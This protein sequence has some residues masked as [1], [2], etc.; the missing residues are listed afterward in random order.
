[1]SILSSCTNSASSPWITLSW[2]QE[3][4]VVLNAWFF[5]FIRCILTTSWMVLQTGFFRVTNDTPFFKFFWGTAYSMQTLSRNYSAFASFFS[6]CDKWPNNQ[7]LI[8]PYTYGLKQPRKLETIGN[9]LL[10]TC[11]R[12]RA[13]GSPQKSDS[14]QIISSSRLKNTF[15]QSLICF[16]RSNSVFVK[17]K[18]LL[19]RDTTIQRM[20]IRRMLIERH[21][22]LHCW[23][24]DFIK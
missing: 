24:S 19:R 5:L 21:F 10:V 1:M 16:Y 13:P 6:H 17:T 11:N 15:F 3:W 2:N 20:T 12:L 4:F 23:L 9:L 14:H 8:R 18:D 7:S 22:W